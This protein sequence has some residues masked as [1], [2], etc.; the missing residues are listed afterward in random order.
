MTE[1]ANMV[2]DKRQQVVG[3]VTE[4]RNRLDKHAV[5]A[6][7]IRARADLT[8]ERKQMAVD[9]VVREARTRVRALIRDARHGASGG[10]SI[11]DAGAAPYSPRSFRAGLTASGES[12]RADLATNNPAYGRTSLGSGRGLVVRP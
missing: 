10:F 9:E 7:E 8:A 6:Q 4:A 5:R 3:M 1:Q 11:G 12:V 2:E